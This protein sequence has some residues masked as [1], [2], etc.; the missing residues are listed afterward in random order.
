MTGGFETRA[1]RNPAGG[2][3]FRPQA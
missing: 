1:W 3:P 2:D